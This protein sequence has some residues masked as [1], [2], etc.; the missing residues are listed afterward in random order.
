MLCL[1]PIRM[2]R[3]LLLQRGYRSYT[4]IS[5][6]CSS[7]SWMYYYYFFYILYHHLLTYLLLPMLIIFFI[8]IV[9]AYFDVTSKRAQARVWKSFIII[10]TI[11]SS[12]F[13][14]GEHSCK[15]AGQLDTPTL[16]FS[17][18]VYVCM[19]SLLL[20]NS[21]CLLPDDDDDRQKRGWF[22]CRSAH[23]N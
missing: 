13:F 12:F 5:R 2:S 8:I 22:Y 20:R 15:C 19:P 18:S 11:K 14:V 23:S 6:R 9:C 21:L 3:L 16:L 7:G 17:S 10:I 1:G 4:A